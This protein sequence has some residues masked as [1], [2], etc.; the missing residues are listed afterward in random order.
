METIARTPFGRGFSAALLLAGFSAHAQLLEPV[1]VRQERIP[2]NLQST[3][4]VPISSTNGT[5]AGSNGLVS[6]VATANP[7]AAAIAAR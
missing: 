1:E 5:P 6:R 2:F 3:N 7:L 4:G